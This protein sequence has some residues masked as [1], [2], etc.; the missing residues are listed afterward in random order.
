M[1]DDGRAINITDEV[2]FKLPGSASSAILVEESKQ[3][4]IQKSPTPTPTTSATEESKLGSPNI[5]NNKSTGVSH[6]PLNQATESSIE[7]S[8]LAGDGQ[9]TYE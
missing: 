7:A 3:Q 2:E 8:I 4:Q 5:E 1:R 6:P 9:M